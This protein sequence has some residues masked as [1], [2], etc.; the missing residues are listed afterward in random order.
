MKLAAAILATVGLGLMADAVY[1]IFTHS[2]WFLAAFG[3][4]IFFFA[5]CK[6]CNE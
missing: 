4:A 1:D 2:W 5:W 6:E 3:M